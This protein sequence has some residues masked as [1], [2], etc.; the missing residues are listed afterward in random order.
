MAV[1]KSKKEFT[2]EEK[3][4]LREIGDKLRKAREEAGLTQME[5]AN[6]I[7]SDRATISHYEGG[8]GGYM[9]GSM[10]YRICYELG[11]EPNDLSPSRLLKNNENEKTDV[12]SID[13]M[14]A[15]IPRAQRELL[16][17][18]LVAMLGTYI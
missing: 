16:M 11:I 18:G 10:I 6:R 4:E 8:T 12:H 1:P 13:A 17:P 14:L 7:D 5:L 15:K 9:G 2:E 3:A